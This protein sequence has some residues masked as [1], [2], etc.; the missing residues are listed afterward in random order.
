MKALTWK[1]VSA[2]LNPSPV[3]EVIAMFAEGLAIRGEES[4]SKEIGGAN[5][6]A[7]PKWNRHLFP[8]VQAWVDRLNWNISPVE[9]RT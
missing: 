4:R 7:A 1:A 2:T 9:P 6:F 8:G 3:F 5:D